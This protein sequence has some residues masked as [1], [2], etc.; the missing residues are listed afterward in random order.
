MSRG[1]RLERAETVTLAMRERGAE[2]A[3]A[4]VADLHANP[5]ESSIVLHFCK[6]C[7]T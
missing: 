7:V 6:S 2:H 1:D 4:T 3:C 5:A